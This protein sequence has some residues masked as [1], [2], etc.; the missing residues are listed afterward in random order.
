MLRFQITSISILSAIIVAGCAAHGSAVAP[1]AQPRM[2]AQKIYQQQGSV[3]TSF[4]IP[5]NG[6]A[7]VP[8]T[9]TEGFDGAIWFCGSDSSG[10]ALL[11]MDLSGIVTS[12]PVDCS[13][14]TRNPDG[15]LFFLSGS[16]PYWTMLGEVNSAGEISQTTLSSSIG[17]VHRMVSAA[18]GSLWCSDN[19]VYIWR[20]STDGKVQTDSGGPG[21]N[22]DLVATPDD[23]MWMLREGAYAT[24]YQ[25]DSSMNIDKTYTLDD[26]ASGFVFA[27]DGGLWFSAG[28]A[29][30]RLD[31]SSGSLTLYPMRYSVTAIDIVQGDPNQLE[32]MTLDGSLVTYDIRAHAVDKSQA[33][34]DWTPVREQDRLH[35]DYPN[36]AVGADM[37][38]WIEDGG[39]AQDVDVYTIRVLSVT[40]S[41]LTLS[42]DVTKGISVHEKYFLK[43]SFSAIST[44]MNVATVSPGTSSGEFMVT[45]VSSGSCGIVLKDTRGNSTSVPVTVN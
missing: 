1:T 28:R 8:G 38:L 32:I 21:G 29:M 9:V 44:N 16:P 14:L 4:P 3:W 10:P 37:N 31:E 17:C 11:R 15:N 5:S 39:Y 12:T 22:V 2:I 19:G 36:M 45:G 42:P 20:V 25:L 43:P 30:G 35:H 27:S 26:N 6:V 40:P 33:I 41:S 24:V 23:K 13:G 34:P 18:D 7:S